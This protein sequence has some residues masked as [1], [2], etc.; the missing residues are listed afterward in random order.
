M[1]KKFTLEKIAYENHPVSRERKRE[2][3]A[4]GFRVLDARFAP[5]GV[6]LAQATEGQYD[7]RVPEQEQREQLIADLTARG[8]AFDPAMSAVELRALS[9]TPPGGGKTDDGLDDLDASQLHALAKERGVTVHH[10]VGADKV[11]EAL[12]EA[13]KGE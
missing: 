1:K 6:A 7:G 8:V 11:R 10:K 2:L 5:A 12:R 3:N 4:K 9:I 13:A